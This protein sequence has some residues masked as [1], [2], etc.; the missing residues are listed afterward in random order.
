MKIS[1]INIYP[2]KSLK[3]ISLEKSKVE[4]RGLQYDRRWMLIDEDSK[5]ITQREIPKL[6]A[7][8]VA[9]D[10][11][12]LTVS[13][14]GF[15]NLNV[16]FTVEGDEI[17][18]RIWDNDC[19]AIPLGKEISEW[20]SNLIDQNCKLVFMPD[21]SKRG[22]NPIFNKNDDIV[23]FADGYPLLLIGENSLGELN[24]RLADSVPM[25]RFRPNLVVRGTPAFAEDAWKSVN[26]G[27]TVFRI[28]KPCARCVVTT[29]DQLSGI[30]SGKEPLKTLA[31]FRMVKDVYPENFHLLGLSETSVL[32]G[33]NMI[34]ETFGATIRI[35]D[36][37]EVG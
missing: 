25:N 11:N 4:Q 37:I 16:P 23:S 12:G 1:E 20:F 8:S 26:I 22:V 24:E 15:E 14:L 29:I 3:G 9:L 10:V 30:V 27:E 28:T 13:T 7:V 2:I 5:F 35:S 36:E 21:S 31:T 18:V 17:S 19:L 33:Q 34:A 6:A 32:F